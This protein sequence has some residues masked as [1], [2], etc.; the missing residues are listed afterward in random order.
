VLRIRLQPLLIEF[1]S[2]G[3]ERLL[4]RL[5][6]H[7]L[8]ALDRPASASAAGPTSVPVSCRGA[9]CGSCRVAVLRGAEHLVEAQPDERDTLRLCG[10]AAHER[11]ACQIW[12]RPAASG[13]VDLAFT[14]LTHPG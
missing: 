13:E 1:E 3:A 7:T 5:D 10:A 6:E 14:A 2:Q 12:L 4:D 11:L 9:R 8:D